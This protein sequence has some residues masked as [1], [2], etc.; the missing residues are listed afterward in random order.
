MLSCQEKP[1]TTEKSQNMF[2]KN[3]EKCR[4]I[5]ETV[6]QIEHIGKL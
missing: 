5:E 3:D 1:I 6:K 2:L 4:K